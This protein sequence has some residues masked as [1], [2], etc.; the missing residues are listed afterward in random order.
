MKKLTL[1][2]KLLRRDYK[3]KLSFKEFME[4]NEKY[5]NGGKLMYQ[6][7][8]TYSGTGNNF[9]FPVAPQSN[10]INNVNSSQYSQGVYNN[11]VPRF[12][13]APQ[14]TYTPPQPQQDT[15]RPLFNPYPEQAPENRVGDTPDDK[16]K[17]DAQKQKNKADAKRYGMLA[18]QLGAVGVDYIGNQIKGDANPDE[19]RSY[20][21][22]TLSETGRG[23]QMGAAFG[24]IGMAAGA[25]GGAAYGLI[26]SKQ[27]ADNYRN[28]MADRTRGRNVGT[29]G[30]SYNPEIARGG[31]V[32]SEAQIAKSYKN[33]NRPMSY[34]RSG[35]SN[36]VAYAG[37]PGYEKFFNEKYANGG[38]IQPT[39]KKMENGGADA[40]IEGGEAVLGNP[41]AV[42][43]YGGADAKHSSSAGFMATGA[44]HGQKNES[45]SEGI[46][47]QSN[48]EVYIG[49][50]RLG[51]DGRKAGNNNPSVAK[52]MEK[53]LSYN[54]K[55]ENEMKK[56][57]YYN[58][59]EALRHNEEMLSKIKA[60]AE[61]GKFMEELNKLVSKK[62]RSYEDIMGFI[63][64]RHPNEAPQ[65]EQASLQEPQ[66]QQET[67]EQMGMEQPQEQGMPDPNMQE[68]E[69]AM[70]QAPEQ[71]MMAPMA[72]GGYVS[73]NKKPM[74]Y[75]SGGMCKGDYVKF[76]HGGMI[77][78]GRVKS[79]NSQTGDFELE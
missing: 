63:Q 2:D 28:D 69:M 11:S 62:D 75:K 22:N 8:G 31:Y 29:L 16:D 65:L 6:T 19:T 15:T 3:D 17:A 61:E 42:T 54:S 50:K 67:P 55:A 60:K 73:N 77:H 68:Q 4:L 48:E 46:P 26:K 59:P 35:G 7:S 18:G 49:S 47:L 58:N 10:M 37:K 64:Q 70:Q 76:E 56:D 1:R 21:G 72:C 79:Y 40:E 74:R 41:Q 13:S 52:L 33:P 12:Q 5:G 57:R 45:G 53:Y 44:N 34:S 39:L 66:P 25:V 38:G 36:G 14:P 23:A 24:P 43:M 27:E 32:Q 51:L 30:N 9:Q 20:I 71:E 78:Q